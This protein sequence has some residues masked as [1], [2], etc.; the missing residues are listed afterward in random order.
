MGIFS[1]C[2]QMIKYSGTNVEIGTIEG[3]IRLPVKIGGIKIKPELL[4]TTSKILETLDWLQ[5]STCKRIETLRKMKDVPQERIVDLIVQQDED[6][7]MIAYMTILL[8]A[9]PK[10]AEAFEKVLADWIA[11][12]VSRDKGKQFK[13]SKPVR[14]PKLQEMERECDSIAKELDRLKSKELELQQHKR[15]LIKDISIEKDTLRFTLCKTADIFKDIS[16]IG[17][18]RLDNSLVDQISLAES[19]FPYLS[20]ALKRKKPFELKESL[21]ILTK[22]A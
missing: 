8:M 4:Q 17:K 11:A 13:P 1:D 3:P 22:G 6:A 14:S 2:K 18:Y 20:E 7:H 12:A 16:D 5:Y 19:V 15:N 21:K 10:S 9:S